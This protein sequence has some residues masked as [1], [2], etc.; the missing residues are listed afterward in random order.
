MTIYNESLSL[1]YYYDTETIFLGGNYGKILTY[2]PNDPLKNPS[3][4]ISVGTLMTSIKSGNWN[5]P[6]VWLCG[7][8][9]KASDIV[10]IAPGH[11]ITLNT[12]G[13]AK[14]IVLKGKMIYEN[15][16]HLYFG[17]EQVGELAVIDLKE[18][19]QSVINPDGGKLIIDD[20]KSPISGFSIDIPEGA[21]S[22]AQTFKI[23]TGKIVKHDLGP[24]F[25]PITNVIRVESGGNFAEKIVKLTVP[26]SIPPNHFAMAFTYSKNSKQFSF[27]PI[28]SISENNIELG[29]TSFGSGSIDSESMSNVLVGDSDHLDVFISSI[30]NSKLVNFE[31]STGF[32]PGEDDWEFPNTGSIF[33]P[34]GNCSGMSR[35]AMYYYNYIKP[36]KK[37]PLFGNKDYGRFIEKNDKG[38]DKLWFDNSLGIRL[39]S[40]V[41]PHQEI[42]LVQEYL[43]IFFQKYINKEI[44]DKQQYYQI[45]YYFLLSNY[46]IGQPKPKPIY[47]ALSNYGK[48]GGHAIILTGVDDNG[49]LVADPNIPGETRT[50]AYNSLGGFEMYKNEEGNGVGEYRTFVGLPQNLFDDTNISFKFKE[51]DLGTVGN[52][53]FKKEKFYVSNINKNTELK[54]GVI[55]YGQFRVLDGCE[56]CKIQ[57]YNSEATRLHTAEYYDETTDLDLNVGKHTIGIYVKK[58]HVDITNVPTYEWSDFQ[59]FDIEVRSAQP[60]V[61]TLYAS[62][63]TP[64][65][66]D[67]TG[68]IKKFGIGGV[69]AYGICY[70]TS[71]ALPTVGDSKTEL[72]P[73]GTLPFDTTFTASINGLN[74]NTIY[75]ARAY[76]RTSS[77]V[78]YGQALTFKTPDNKPL[79]ITQSVLDITHS[80]AKVLSRIENIKFGGAY[81]YGVC[82]SSSN[83]LPDISNSRIEFTASANP[84][85]DTTFTAQLAGLID[86]T[87]Y[88][89]RTYA[90]STSGV[91]YGQV[92]TFQTKPKPEFDQELIIGTYNL[93]SIR[94]GEQGSGTAVFSPSGWSIQLWSNTNKS[95]TPWYSNGGT[96][97]F[98][99]KSEV[100]LIRPDTPDCACAPCYNANGYCSKLPVG[101]IFNSVVNGT[102]IPQPTFSFSDD[103]VNATS[104]IG[105][106]TVWTKVN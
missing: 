30:E 59:W 75:Y 21:Y 79:A 5:D 11:T 45:L 69:T 73:T 72:I 58:R 36:L 41:Q 46:S 93:V 2:I 61:S 44:F 63:I 8:T 85:D 98:V 19:K 1:I 96:L 97:A 67:V 100:P 74:I 27:L 48:E 12:V 25:N 94:Q 56:D 14:D 101:W 42:L 99:G 34:N 18:I 89:T 90:K 49:L 16:G 40:V 57:I 87:T 78:Y 106:Q 50:I 68:M 29:A 84:P 103:A 55:I 6:K 9:P 81:A 39:V 77:Q 23:S 105:G 51:A 70:S 28:L 102:S 26:I 24:N 60:E 10:T 15:G 92:L 13:V 35:T 64:T 80:K 47:L 37:K 52:D 3:N 54:D 7:R 20:P 31:G 95:G 71:N 33:T 104:I 38:N 88:Y 76:A 82:Y 65:V 62:N 53:K 66:S 17:A 91:Y 86:N 32:T 83:A 22:T 43:S 4:P